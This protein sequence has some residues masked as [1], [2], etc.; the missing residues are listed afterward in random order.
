M[1][2]A[3]VMVIDRQVAAAEIAG[4]IIGG[5]AWA[6]AGGRRRTLAAAGALATAVVLGAL[7]PFRWGPA[8]PFCWI[9]LQPLFGLPGSAA[10]AVL[11]RKLFCYGSAIWLCH[12]AGWRYS[13]T[14][15]VA[16]LVL[17]VMEA[18][19]THL[20]GHSPEITDPILALAA[21]GALALARTPEEEAHVPN[22]GDSPA[23]AGMSRLETVR[24][25]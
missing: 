16:A 20:P 17:A 18:L 13:R 15:A 25:P 23:R 21:A 8:A 7:A 3:R 11:S 22:S 4:A 5:L 14:G 24:L 2:P 9:P 12:K 19:Q 1:V 10:L 6:A